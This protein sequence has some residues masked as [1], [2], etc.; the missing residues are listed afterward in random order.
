[1]RVDA[2]CD[3]MKVSNAERTRL[4]AAVRRVGVHPGMD[5]KAMRAALYEQGREAVEDQLVLAAALARA[6]GRALA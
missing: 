6:P 1:M 2:L 4:T 3:A 5:R